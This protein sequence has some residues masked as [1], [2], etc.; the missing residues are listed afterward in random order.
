[1]CT[2][3]SW[4]NVNKTE[5]VSNVYCSFVEECKQNICSIKCVLQF[6]GGM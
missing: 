5:A 2:A 4:R 1:M 6:L 3:V